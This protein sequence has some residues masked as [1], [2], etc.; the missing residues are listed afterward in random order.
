MKLCFLLLQTGPVQ[1]NSVDC[2]VFSVMYAECVCRGGA[3]TFTQDK[4][5]FLRKVVAYEILTQ[6]LIS[7]TN[8]VK[9]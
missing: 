9:V 2:G 4:M 1:T 7:I 6:E 8:Q 5:P 3:L